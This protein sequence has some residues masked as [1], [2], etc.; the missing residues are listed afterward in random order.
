MENMETIGLNSHELKVLDILGF[1]KEES[2]LLA[3]L[4]R[5]L[6]NDSKGVEEVHAKGISRRSIYSM[7]KKISRSF[8]SKEKNIDSDQYDEEAEYLCSRLIPREKDRVFP[9]LHPDGDIIFC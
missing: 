1:K 7:I 4:K 8:S 3:F 5:V 9:E 2:S 6:F